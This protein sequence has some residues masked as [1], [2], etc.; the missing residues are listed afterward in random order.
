LQQL[1]LAIIAVGVQ[2]VQPVLN[3]RMLDL[4]PRARGSAASVQSCVSIMISAAVFGQLVPLLSGSL[5]TLS[6][7]SCVGAVIAFGL[8]RLARHT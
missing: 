6:L 3:L 8:W 5:L 1:L 7:G 2:L 4:F